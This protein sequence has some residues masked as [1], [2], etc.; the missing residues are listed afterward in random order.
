MAECLSLLVQKGFC[1]VLMPWQ[2]CGCLLYFPL[3][4]VSRWKLGTCQESKMLI[5]K[6]N[7]C[8]CHAAHHCQLSST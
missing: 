7:A 2:I 5:E 3:H 4:A 8:S 1:S 6:C